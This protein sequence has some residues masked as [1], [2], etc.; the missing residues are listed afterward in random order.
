MRSIDEIKQNVLNFS[1][2]IHVSYRPDNE[3][4]FEFS[5]SG[6]TVRPTVNQL[7]TDTIIYNALSKSYGNS[8]LK[9]GFRGAL[10]MFFRMS[11]FSKSSF[12]SASF[13]LSHMQNLVSPY[14]YVDSL[15]NRISTYRN[16]NGNWGMSLGA[17]YDTPLKNKRFTIDATTNMSYQ[18]RVGYTNWRKSTTHDWVVSGRTTCRFATKDY[19]LATHIQLGGA[20]R[21]LKNNRVVE[22]QR[23]I[24]DG[25]VSYHI[26][27]QLPYAFIF[28][29]NLD[30]R[31]YVGYEA[32]IAENECI[33][34]IELAK[35]ILKSKRLTLALAFYDVLDG[36][37]NFTRTISTEQVSD[38]S[39][40]SLN[41]YILL[42]ISYRLGG[43]G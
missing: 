39:S 29:N 41:R 14:V 22:Q 36:R 21:I 11:D 32:G 3:K 26:E 31:F 15:A 35:N 2:F 24:F 38:V 6:Q 40:Q 13:Q 17:T 33:W 9:P 28:R 25:V 27:W 18:S 10:M 23:D 7:S 8:R 5:Y 20:Y 37:N 16:V 30:Y 34:N 12:F 19:R 43:N 4:A 42:S 1:P